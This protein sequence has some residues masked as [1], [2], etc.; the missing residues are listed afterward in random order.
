[1]SPS[2]IVI[3]GLIASGKST[4]AEIL[5]EKGYEL[6]SADEVNRDLIKEGGKN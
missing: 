5:K 2:R 4:V 6:I 3:T 1:M